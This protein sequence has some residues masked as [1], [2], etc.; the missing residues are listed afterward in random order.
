MQSQ[1]FDHTI[2]ILDSVQELDRI[3]M[4]KLEKPIKIWLRI[5]IDEEP[6][7]AYY[8]SRLGRNKRELLELVKEKI[9]AFARSLKAFTNKE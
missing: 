6:Q 2:T 9:Q 5:T 4:H 1:G 7:A 3:T 8:T